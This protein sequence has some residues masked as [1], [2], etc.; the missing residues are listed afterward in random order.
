MGLH[1]QSA[2]RR[3]LMH[4]GAA[5]VAASSASALLAAYGGEGFSLV[6]DSTAPS[7]KIS[8]STT[9]SNDWD[10][11]LGDGYSVQD[12][13]KNRSF[14][15]YTG[16][17]ASGKMLMQADGY[18]KPVRHNLIPMSNSFGSGAWTRTAV[19]S[20]YGQTDADGGSTASLI[21]ESNTST[22]VLYTT[23]AFTTA[24]NVPYT[25]SVKIKKGNSTWVRL[26]FGTSGG[27]FTNGVQ[28]W[29]NLDTVA[30]GTAATTGT[31]SYISSSIT[32]TTNSYYI[33]TLTASQ[34]STTGAFIVSTAT[35][36][37]SATRTTSGTYYICHAM[38]N[39]G[40][41]ALEYV[42]SEAH[43][44]V[45]Q[46]RTLGT[47]WTATDVTVG[48]NATTSPDGTTSA[49]SLTE[50]VAGTAL[51]RSTAFTVPAS[52]TV[53]AYF[54]LKTSTAT[55]VRL[56]LADGSDTNGLR[57]WFNLSTGAK[58]TLTAIGSGTAT[59]SNITACGNG[60][61]LCDITGVCSTSTSLTMSLSS[62]SADASNTRVNSV[63]YYADCAQATLSAAPLKFVETGA[64]AVY[65][66]HFDLPIEYNT[67]G[68]VKA[69]TR[70]QA[71]TNINLTSNTNA[72]D[73]SGINL[74]VAENSSDVT[75][76]YGTLLATKLTASGGSAI[77]LFYR[78]TGAS[79]SSGTSYCY[80]F[81]V[82]SGTAQYVQILLDGGAFSTYDYANFDI[83]NG[84]AGTSSAGSSS[85]IIDCNNGWYRIW[86]TASA[87]VTG[88]A[89]LGYLSVQSSGS[90]A[91]NAASDIDGM[92]CYVQ[93]M[94]F[95]A[96]P[97]STIG[98]SSPIVTGSAAV[99]RAADVIEFSNRVLGW[100]DA[101]LS[102]Y[103]KATLGSIAAT[104]RLCAIDDGTA[105]ETHHLS[106]VASTGVYNSTTV[107]GGVTQAN[108]STGNAV[109]AGTAFKA[110]TSIK[111]N[112]LAAALNNG[113]VATDTSITMPTVHTVRLG[114]GLSAAAP[115][116]GGIHE[117]MIVPTDIT[118][119]Q[120]GSLTT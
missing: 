74:T 48:N 12:F 64:S 42:S 34:D 109:T 86:I 92:T 62:A 98:P 117:F 63:V 51:L 20:T 84:T 13:F 50:G 73:Y 56:T 101:T 6:F 38:A 43:N 105:N 60:W 52:S 8:D 90:A 81:F 69:L 85:G 23:T 91:Y 115:S 118:D 31:A 49:E 119:A 103:T 44:L 45:I 46:S 83:Q 22:S 75:D 41:Q 10:S 66:P 15:S 95:E 70:E 17:V 40:S 18:I 14:T 111:V 77:H 35:A 4:G 120:L 107:D 55:W 76:I 30:T 36:D 116:T 93:Q 25:I 78:G 5:D 61:Y 57:Q 29:Y 54:Y 59:S 104:Q 79:I 99:T 102:V 27:T 19:T 65:N 21:T 47:S 1:R 9:P 108:A 68:T 37:A 112:D 7:L 26:A 11:D 53:T 114:A 24:A 110:A 39:A 97:A 2:F 33:L 87:T 71:R 67:D 32:A 80:S 28:Q 88:A 16:P 3:I 82:K 58:G 106:I 100:S 94:Q 113:T 96:V 72:T 89:T